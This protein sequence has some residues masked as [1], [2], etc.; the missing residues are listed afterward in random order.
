MNAIDEERGAGRMHAV[1][2]VKLV[3][4]L[5]GVTSESVV[6]LLT[7]FVLGILGES[8]MLA[9]TELCD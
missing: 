5:G 6:L 2:V 7:T 9:V 8:M 4:G 1:D 3:G